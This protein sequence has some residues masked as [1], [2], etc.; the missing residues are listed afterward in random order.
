VRHVFQFH[1]THPRPKWG[2]HPHPRWGPDRCPQFIL[3]SPDRCWTGIKKIILFWF[4]FWF[5]L[6]FGF[7]FFIVMFLFHMYFQYY[8]FGVQDCNILQHHI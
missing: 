5:F 8:F 4:W 6:F 3:L 1:C 2:V 7:N